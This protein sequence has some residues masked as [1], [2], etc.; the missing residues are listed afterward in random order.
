MKITIAVSL[1][2]VYGCFVTGTLVTPCRV[3]CVFLHL[4]ECLMFPEDMMM[5]YTV[6]LNSIIL[7]Y[8]IYLCTMH[9][10]ALILVHCADVPW[11]RR[12]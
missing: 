9:V 12:L 7:I 1:V 11:S 3:G 8:I 2:S 6:V 5:I 10:P 4:L